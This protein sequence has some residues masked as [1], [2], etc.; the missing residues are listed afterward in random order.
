MFNRRGLAIFL[1]HAP[2]FAARR[3]GQSLLIIQYF[4]A[5]RTSSTDVP[6]HMCPEQDG[7]FIYS[8]PLQFGERKRWCPAPASS[9]QIWDR[10]C[11]EDAISTLQLANDLHKEARGIS[12]YQFVG[13]DGRVHL[14]QK[15]LVS[16]LATTVRQLQKHYRFEAL[17][18][19]CIRVFALEDLSLP[20]A[21][22]MECVEADQADPLGLNIL[23]RHALAEAVRLRTQST[24]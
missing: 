3:N 17:P 5:F 2:W 10:R 23:L 22:M 14:L 13:S 1:E 16:V 15:Q 7:D 21:L 24:A 8:D 4:A 9:F 18:G 20:V 11:Q 12:F 19:H 6:S